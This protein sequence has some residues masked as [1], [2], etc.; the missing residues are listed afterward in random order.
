L[1]AVVGRDQLALANARLQLAEQGA[2][3]AG[4]GA[5]GLLIA[6]VGAPLAAAVDAVSYFGSAALLAGI[7]LPEAAHSESVPAG[8]MRSIGEGIGVVLRDANLRP[9]ALVGALVGFFGRMLWAVL[10]LYLVRDARLSAAQVGLVLSVAGAGFVAGAL[11]APR[12]TRSLGLGRAATVAIIV[13][14]A[15]L[16]A[17]GLAPPRSAAVSA[18]AGLF[19]Y[20]V[21]AVVWQVAVTTLRQS[22]T[23]PAL[24]GRV[25]AT[26]RVISAGPIPL[27]ALAGGALAAGVGLRPTLL[28]AGG[29][30]LLAAL[31]VLGSGLPRLGG[32]PTRQV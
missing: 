1:P 21:A 11:V 10:L 22:L 6:A 20:G 18:A 3:V 31:S 29:A 28:L 12:L 7:K 19:I 32:L 30:S 23:L 16:A 15:G 4:P 2:A 24:L 27:A 13:A 17:I 8:L 25:T 26:M 9:I 14:A 5:A